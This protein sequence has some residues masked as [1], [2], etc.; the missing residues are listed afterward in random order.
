MLVKQKGEFVLLYKKI[1]YGICR[2]VD[3]SKYPNAKTGLKTTQMLHKNK[4]CVSAALPGQCVLQGLVLV[5]IV[6][7][8]DVG[9]AAERSVVVGRCCCCHL[10]V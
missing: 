4:A 8:V 5:M 6:D 7:V 2:G 10:V 1:V 9:V 3:K